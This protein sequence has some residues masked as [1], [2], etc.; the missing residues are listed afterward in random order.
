MVILCWIVG[1]FQETRQRFSPS[2]TPQNQHS[3]NPVPFLPCLFPSEPH[4]F[5]K[6]RYPQIQQHP[7]QGL[8]VVFCASP[9]AGPHLPRQGHRPC[10]SLAPS[11]LCMAQTTRAP[12]TDPPPARLALHSCCQNAAFSSQ[13]SHCRAGPPQPPSAG[14]V[15]WLWQ[16]L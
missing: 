1:E 16:P 4:T 13:Q 15:P 3:V 14:N 11:N 10:L 7:L 9:Q 8:L 12:S 5:C 2:R 6:W